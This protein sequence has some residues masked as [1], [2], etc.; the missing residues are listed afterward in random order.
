MDIFDVTGIIL[1]GGQSSRMGEEKGLALLNRKPLVSYAVDA[2]KPVC[3]SLVISANNFQK[4]YEKYGYE[5]VEDQIKGIGP[6]GGVFSCIHRSS[7]RFNIVMSCDTPFVTPCLFQYL[8]DSIENFQAA[9]PVHD[10]GFIEPLCGVYATNVIWS[11]QLSIEKRNYKMLDFLK[12]IKYK[13]V[14]IHNNLPF[15]KDDLFVNIN[16]RKDLKSQSAGGNEKS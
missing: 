4:E 16:T 1:A 7:T 14:D 15:Y 9:I 5:V 3:G 12:D 6:M 2:L 8:L 11:L 10:A 13:K